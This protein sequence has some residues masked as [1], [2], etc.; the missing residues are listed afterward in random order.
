MEQLEIGTLLEGDQ[1]LLRRATDE[2]AAQP[3]DEERMEVPDGDSSWLQTTI[4]KPVAVTGPGT[5]LG[6]ATRRLEFVPTA[7][8]G[9]RFERTDLAQ[10]L[11]IEVSVRNV[12]TTARNIVLC[13]GSPHN[14]MRM[15][16]H[17]VALKY[18]GLDN[19]LIRLDSGDPPLFDRS[20]MDLVEALERAEIVQQHEPARIF[21]VKE[22]VS[23]T[24]PNGGFLTFLPA[25]DGNRR[26]TVDCAVN[27]PTAIGRQRIRFDVNPQTFR[28][29]AA[30]R[31]NTNMWMMLYC[32]TV[33]KVFADT[34]NLGYT[35]DNILVAGPRHYVNKPLLVHNG[36]SLEAVWHRAV[37]DLLAAV[38][39]IDMGRLAGHIISYKAGHTVDCDMIRLLYQRDLLEEI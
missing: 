25:R 9:W 30:A 7:K 13:S 5:F 23:I 18:M 21:S 38:A 4:A 26:L 12:W 29:G 39:L 1:E 2:M 32:K 8:P 31:T 14:Y 6:K 15:V 17:I 16:E 34:R 27:F 24:T 33:G 22:P 37:L 28:Y 20:S 3:V 11:D 19:V 36:K 35:L 10:S